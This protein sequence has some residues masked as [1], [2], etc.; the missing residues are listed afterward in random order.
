MSE[1]TVSHLVY[2]LPFAK[3]DGHYL[4]THK[5]SIID[6]HNKNAP[7]VALLAKDMQDW[8][9]DFAYYLKTDKESKLL[10]ESVDTGGGYTVPEEFRAVMLQY[11]MT[12]TL[13]WPKATVWPMQGEK[14]SMP[15]LLQ[16][17]DVE[18]V[19]FDHYSGV[20]FEWVEEGG[21]KPETQPEFGFLELIVHELA[22]YT[23]VTNT[24]LD[25]SFINLINYLTR[26]FRAARYWYTDKSF[27]DG[28]GGKQ[29][30]GIYND[31]SILSV[32]RAVAG[33][34]TFDDILR[35]DS[36]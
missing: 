19:Y 1:A 14:L 8:V 25:D 3:V 20:T 7:W 4:T 31:P 2:T 15:K 22:G 12:E 36:R 6:L 18:D 9:K 28:T 10:S 5:G 16:N 17:P 34:V 32:N 35:M 26:L 13:I 11:D 29:P 27:L 24:L 23:E 30:L 21:T 33:D